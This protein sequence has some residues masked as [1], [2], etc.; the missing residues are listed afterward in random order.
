M[1]LLTADR[2][3]AVLRKGTSARLDMDA[4]AHFQVGQRVLAGNIHPRG[5]T[6]IPRYVRGQPGVVQRDH[7]VFVFPDSHAASDAL[8][9][10]HVYMRVLRSC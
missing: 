8:C 3:E 7:G 6:R 9:P 4:P 2:V 10:Q 5:H 1:P